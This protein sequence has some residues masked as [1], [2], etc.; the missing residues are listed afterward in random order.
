MA[1]RV[2]SAGP[3]RLRTCIVL[4]LI[5]I[6]RALCKYVGNRPTLNVVLSAAVLNST[7]DETNITRF[8][9]GAGAAYSCVFS[10]PTRLDVVRVPF[11]D[12]WFADSF[13][14]STA[15]V[16]AVLEV[17]LVAPTTDGYVTPSVPMLLFPLI[18]LPPHYP[19]TRNSM[20]FHPP[21]KSPTRNGISDK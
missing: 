13:C 11:L 15:G 17:P 5:R 9:V 18:T 12:R 16:H 1:R 19:R 3:T 7:F 8:G 4:K 2:F 21:S 14:L 6:A 10:S 20:S